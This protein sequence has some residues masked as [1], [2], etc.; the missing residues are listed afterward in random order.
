M[1]CTK[2][3]AA[4]FLRSCSCRTAGV[5]RGVSSIGEKEEDRGPLRKTLSQDIVLGGSTIPQ[6]AESVQGNEKSG[7]AVESRAT[8]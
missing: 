2:H 3:L 6:S 4:L 7:C 8:Q 1:P 5:T